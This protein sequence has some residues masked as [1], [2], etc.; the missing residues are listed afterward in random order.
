MTAD[1]ATDAP[2]TEAT[3]PATEAP[4]TAS[5]A[6]SEAL[7]A[8]R[9]TKMDELYE[10]Q[11]YTIEAE[12]KLKD[13]K[14][15]ITPF[16]NKGSNGYLLKN[17]DPNADGE[18]KTHIIGRSVLDQVAEVYSAVELPAKTRKRRT[19]EEKAA[20][21]V[22]VKAERAAKKEQRDAERAAAAQAKADEKMR[23]RMEAA[24]DI[25]RQVA[26]Q[27]AAAQAAEVAA[28]NAAGDAEDTAGA[29]APATATVTE[30]DD[31]LANV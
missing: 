27:K 18:K 8:A 10:G 22:R 2:A 24:A 15:F 3:A 6:R 4:P 16:G 31:L 21:D 25:E 13:G 20:D 5:A 23:I 1:I 29:P 30:D 28:A 14:K 7:A 12:I 11:K 17:V 19:A 26:E 9:K